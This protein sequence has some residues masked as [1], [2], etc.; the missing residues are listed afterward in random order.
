[1]TTETVLVTVC[2]ITIPG[3]IILGQRESTTDVVDST[4]PSPELLSALRAVESSE[5]GD[6]VSEQGARGLYQ[7]M[8]GT[9][10]DHSRGVPFSQAFDPAE[11]EI[12]AVRYL[13]WIR[14][15]LSL[16]E[17]RGEDSIPLDHILSCWHGGIGNFRKS[18]YH[19]SRMNP[20]TRRFVN[21]IEER[22]ETP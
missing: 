19:P 7:I 16:W 8:H 6:A 18:Q 4:F 9:W 13:Q 11:N 14:G 21:H 2:L 10:E 5:R 20:T 3:V 1:M 17:G 15:T 12:V 22:M